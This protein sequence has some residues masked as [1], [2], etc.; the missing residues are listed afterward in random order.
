MSK[1]YTKDDVFY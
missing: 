1:K